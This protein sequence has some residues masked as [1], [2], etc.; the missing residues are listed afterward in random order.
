MSRR[1]L[2]GFTLIELLVVIAIIAILAAILFP[3][4]ANARE[5]GRQASCSSNLR[6]IGLAYLQYQTDNDGDTVPW[7][8]YLTDPNATPWVYQM[9][10]A[11]MSY[12][13]SDQKYDASKGSLQPYM[14]SVQI[15]DCLSAGDL[16]GAPAIS[17]GMNE[18]VSP[19]DDDASGYVGVNDGDVQA[20]AE[21]VLF[22]DAALYWKNELQRG[23]FL[24]PPAESLD[25]DWATL[26]GRHNGFANVLWMDGHVKAARPSYPGTT[27]NAIEAKALRV[28]VLL[29]PR[30]P[31]DGGPSDCAKDASGDCKEDYYYL[32]K[33]PGG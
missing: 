3:V 14:K 27:G 23:Q 20:P 11:Q 13:G 33:K 28:G 18:N 29:N 30:Y 2:Q 9:W 17:L 24:S 5:K 19:W 15:E 21:T 26:H 22:A 7:G 1:F 31:A 10:Y 32:L 6:Q 12:D 16:P 25:S 4:F 8:Y